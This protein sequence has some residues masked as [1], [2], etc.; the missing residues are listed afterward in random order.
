MD[1]YKH[2]SPP[3]HLLLPVTQT[4]LSLAESHSLTVVNTRGTLG[5]T[6]FVLLA[7][8]QLAIASFCAH[9]T[10]QTEKYSRRVGRSSFWSFPVRLKLEASTAVVFVNWTAC[11]PETARL[12]PRH[13]VR[14]HGYPAALNAVAVHVPASPQATASA[15][16]PRGRTQSQA[17]K[18]AASCPRA[19]SRSRPKYRSTRPA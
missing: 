1:R 15:S 4:R 11:F 18:C 14:H 17:C 10:I 9:N 13:R 19:A 12:S 3:P 8:V 7:T 16:T 6:P 2:F 5:S